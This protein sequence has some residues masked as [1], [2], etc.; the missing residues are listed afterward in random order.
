MPKL[1]NKEELLKFMEEEHQQHFKIASLLAVANGGAFGTCATLWKDY[2]SSPQYNGV[3]ILFIILGTGLV[4]SILN[5]GL[6]FVIRN[7]VRSALMSHQDPN[8]LSGALALQ[9]AYYLT[10]VV[11]KTALLAAIGFVVWRSRLL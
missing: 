9:I 5:Y 6:V 2:A 11:A 7:A 1:T 3:G 10:V 8:D 4:A